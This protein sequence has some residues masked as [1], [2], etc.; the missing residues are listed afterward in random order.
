MALVGSM[1][2]HFDSNGT[3]PASRKGALKFWPVN[4]TAIVLP[5]LTACGLA[6]LITI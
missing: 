3:E 1:E 4:S 2:V 5:G 6:L